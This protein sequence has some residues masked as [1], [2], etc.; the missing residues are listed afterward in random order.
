MQFTF[1]VDQEEINFDFT[2][3]RQEEK[4][5]LSTLTVQKVL[6]AKDCG[7]VSDEAYHELRKA[8]PEKKQEEVPSLYA[9]RQERQRQNKEIEIKQIKEVSSTYIFSKV[10]PCS[11]FTITRESGQHD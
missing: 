1:A 6:H 9:L 7:V 8:L 10:R 5:I 3:T 2:D 4:Q 11:V